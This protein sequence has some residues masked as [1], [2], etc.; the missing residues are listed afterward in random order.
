MKLFRSLS[1]LALLFIPS[2]FALAQD[3]VSLV[4]QKQVH[5]DLAIAGAAVGFAARTSERTSFGVE[6]GGGGNWVNYMLIGGN[7]FAARGAKGSSVVELAHA[8]VF[9]RTRFSERQHLDLG[10]KASAFLHFD[11]S[12]DDPG[13]GYFIGLNAKYTWA[14]WRRLNLASEMDIGRYAEPG[15]GKCISGCE[16]IGEFGINVAPIL[17][18]FTIP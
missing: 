12:D 9:V 7:H 4:P 3:S 15:N 6:I 11:N 17:V 2:L 10:A 18:R 1:A 8:T 5:L 14:K 16:G 13:G